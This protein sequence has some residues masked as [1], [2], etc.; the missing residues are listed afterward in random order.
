[1]D[2]HALRY[3]YG[4]LLHHNGADDKTLQSLLGPATIRA[5]MEICAKDDSTIEAK[6]LERLSFL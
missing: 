2:L 4:T 5:T 1:M 6:A 3:T